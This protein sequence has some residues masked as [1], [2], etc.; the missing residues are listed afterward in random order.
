[1]GDVR[2]QWHGLK[3]RIPNALFAKTFGTLAAGFV[4]SLC[5]QKRYVQVRGMIISVFTC[6]KKQCQYSYPLKE[7]ERETEGHV[8]SGIV[9]EKVVPRIVIPIAEP[10]KGFCAFLPAFYEDS[11][12]VIRVFPVLV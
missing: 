11:S 2:C 4:L 12:I 3:A 5:Q 10:H 1:M 8:E 6:S 9:A 7:F